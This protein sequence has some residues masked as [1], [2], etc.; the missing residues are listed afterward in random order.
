MT[1]STKA[2]IPEDL[3]GAYLE[4]QMNYNP[5]PGE[6]ASYIERIAAL[7]TER[8]RLDSCLQDANHELSNMDNLTEE[9]AELRAENERLKAPVSD[10]EKKSIA[11]RFGGGS[12]ENEF[13]RIIAARANPKVLHYQIRRIND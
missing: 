3:R 5:M 10:E 9:L 8:D 2:P 11:F 1:Y 7:E 12:V 4:A 6:V 13:D